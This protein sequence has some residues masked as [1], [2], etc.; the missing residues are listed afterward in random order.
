VVEG[1]VNCPIPVSY[2]NKP[3]INAGALP[4]KTTNLLCGAASLNAATEHLGDKWAKNMIDKKDTIVDA[5]FNA[6]LSEFG[7][8]YNQQP[9]SNSVVFRVVGYTE[10]FDDRVTLY[11]TNYTVAPGN[12]TKRDKTVFTYPP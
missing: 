5:W 6:G 10:C 3:V 2:G 11:A 1:R 4:L 7:K 9:F 8:S 12:I